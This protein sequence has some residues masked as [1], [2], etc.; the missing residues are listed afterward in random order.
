MATTADVGPP[1]RRT[2]AERR[3]GT[4][5]ALLRATVEALV[6]LG[7]ARTTTQEVQRRAGVSRGALTHHFTSK[8]ELMLAAM[9]HLYEEFSA[10]VRRAAAELPEESTA[11]VRL[12]VELV[13]QRFHGPLFVAAMEL[14]TAARTDPELRAALL[15]HERRLGAQLRQLAFEV[16]GEQVARH[17]AAE[18]MYQ[19]LLT[20]MRGQALTYALQPDAPRDQFLQHWLT[21]IEAFTR[22]AA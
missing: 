12:G 17:P 9:D 10:S 4:R 1:L 5:T 15:P 13:W 21:I 22:P 7:Y 16:F 8:A 3:A 6:E 20:S 19:V 2:Q 11:R 18:A 14:W